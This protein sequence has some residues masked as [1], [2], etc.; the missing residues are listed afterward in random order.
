M[1]SN[2]KEYQKA[3]REGQ[4]VKDNLDKINI[5]F[6][7]NNITKEDINKIY[8]KKVGNKAQEKLLKNILNLI[9][10]IEAHKESLEVFGVVTKTVTGTIKVNPSEKSLRECM[11]QL[12][13]L[14]RELEE[15]LV[16]TT[17]DREVTDLESLIS[18]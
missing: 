2:T 7:I 9:D 1:G 12:S 14:I 17:I 8:I 6:D 15:N 18:L 10:L 4:K 11:L 3:Y 5:K 16:T 13:K